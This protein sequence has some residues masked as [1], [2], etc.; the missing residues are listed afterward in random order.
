[1][2]KQL[3]PFYYFVLSLFI[4]TAGSCKRNG[5][6]QNRL[7]QEHFAG[8]YDKL[9]IDTSDGMTILHFE[10]NE[11][12]ENGIVVTIVSSYPA[13]ELIV[14][15][16]SGVSISQFNSFIEGSKSAGSSLNIIDS[17]AMDSIYLVRIDTA[18]LAGTKA[19]SERLMRTTL[20]KYAEPNYLLTHTSNQ[21]PYILDPAQWTFFNHG[22]EH[23]QYG[24][25]FDAD[26]DAIEAI[27]R[28]KDGQI[29]MQ[30]VTVAIIDG[31]IDIFHYA[32]KNRL[33]KNPGENTNN[34][35]DD[36]GNGYINDEFGW[37]FKSKT[38]I[39]VDND[40]HGTHVAGVIG[41]DPIPIAHNP[42]V[43]YNAKLMILKTTE[44]TSH[45]I[46]NLIDALKYAKLKRADVI[47]M[48]LGSFDHSTPLRDAIED[49]IN[50]N[51]P[52]VAALGNKYTDIIQQPY[53]P[54]CYGLVIGVANSNKYDELSASSN[55]GYNP[56]WNPSMIAAPGEEIFSTIPGS[57][58]GYMTGTSMAAPHVAGTVAL[59][60]SMDP[61]ISVIRIRNRLSDGADEIPALINKTD[62]GRRLNVYKTLFAP[63]QTFDGSGVPYQDQLVGGRARRNLTPYANSH[64]PGID[65]KT[66]Q[67]AFRIAAM[68]QLK[69]MRNEDKGAYFILMNNIDWHD[70]N[71][72]RKP[73]EG[74]FTGTLI[75]Q[76]FTIKNFDYQAGYPAGLFMRLGAN[77]K[78]QRLKFSGVNLKGGTGVG[79][80]SPVM[81]G[82]II[83][84]VQVEGII[85]G[86]SHVGGLFGTTN[87]GIIRN[88]YF[89]GSIICNELNGK[90][91]NFGGISGRSDK[92]DYLNCHVQSR[93]T[94]L[95]NCGGIAGQMSGFIENCYANGMIRGT[96][97]VG[98]LVGFKLAG[99]IRD[100]YA[101]GTVRGTENAGGLIGK[102]RE[103]FLTHCY[104]YVDVTCPSF[105]GGLIGKGYSFNMNSCYYLDNGTNR[106]GAGGSPKSHY[107]MQQAATFAGWFPSSS[108]EMKYWM[109]PSLKGLPRSIG[110]L[111]LAG[112]MDSSNTQAGFVERKLPASKE[113]DIPVRMVWTWDDFVLY[114]NSPELYERQL[115]INSNDVVTLSFR[116]KSNRAFTKNGYH[117]WA[118]I[119]LDNKTGQQIK[120]WEA[121]S[122]I[123]VRC[124]TNQ[125]LSKSV[126]IPGVYVN[127]FKGDFVFGPLR[128]N[129][130]E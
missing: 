19:F 4:L 42:G 91:A 129:Y 65:G 18:G 112:R 126:S 26:I 80:I 61:A 3:S 88:C 90:G 59:L 100:S 106:A 52:V 67:T 87:G 39:L 110:S 53:Y 62:H 49:V 103:T 84:D 128:M 47:N 28:L 85:K 22:I 68:H 57:N 77:A 10:K 29:P 107:E 15:L 58:Y 31:G 122:G 43:S 11:K 86:V 82:S 115:I 94:G 121:F 13:N 99:D 113:D 23:N 109:L 108:W 50:A 89:E 118:R 97:N 37:N 20:F 93:I 127:G 27:G 24:G 69:N 104:A 92:T 48:S 36:D 79:V 105:N 76:G 98:G 102:I 114:S 64:E 120:L 9:R 66:P 7:S 95:E 60:K 116:L 75:G 72:D 17:L 44:D 33:W 78:I 96:K 56:Q 2:T 101:E 81:S 111:Y 83:D 130:C 123:P 35:T 70:G 1:M 71:H 125:R 32:L 38:P 5:A 6:V 30:P 45:S 51:I 8:S 34:N 16:K 25:K 46:F 119:K 54:A 73:I 63:S 74:T 55:Y 41:A 40:G 21:F 124:T 117:F 14:R 12:R